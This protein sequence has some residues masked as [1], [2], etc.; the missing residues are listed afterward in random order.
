MKKIILATAIAATMGSSTAFAAGPAVGDTD[1]TSATVSWEATIPTVVAGE[2]VT[3]T[4]QGGGV[5]KAG[6][7][8]VNA[9]GTFASEPVTLEVHYYDSASG[10]VSGPVVADG[11]TETV[12]GSGIAVNEITYTAVK[13]VEFSSKNGEDLSAVKAQLLNAGSTVAINSP[14]SATGAEAYRTE[15]TI[16]ND[17]SSRLDVTAGDVITAT[18]V[19]RADIPFVAAK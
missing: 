12:S 17:M 13:D 3:F 8:N 15:W 14:V 16:Q 9:D 10:K 19:I 7:L 11:S 1:H 5:L 2:W 4:G 6:Q 18:T